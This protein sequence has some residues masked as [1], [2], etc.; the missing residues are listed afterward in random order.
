MAGFEV[1]TKQS[2]PTRS[3][4][5]PLNMMWLG[6]KQTSSVNRKQNSV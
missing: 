6:K 1:S 3:Q 4:Q 2:Y 5:G